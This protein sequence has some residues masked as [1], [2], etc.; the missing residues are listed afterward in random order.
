MLDIHKQFQLLN[1]SKGQAEKNLKMANMKNLGD[2]REEF[3]KR[4]LLQAFF[5]LLLAVIINV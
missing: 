5:P 3:F 2:A 1:E 4:N